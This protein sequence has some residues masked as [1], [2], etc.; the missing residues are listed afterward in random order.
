M[1]E[2]FDPYHKWLGIRPKDQPPNHYR[3]LGIELFENDLD[4][5]AS[6]ADQR[7]AHVRSY[8]TGKNSELSQKILNQIAAARVCLL[9]GRKKEQYDLALQGQ[10][11]SLPGT[12]PSLPV[13]VYSVESATAAPKVAEESPVLFSP[14]RSAVAGP[15]PRRKFGS[16]LMIFVVLFVLIGVVVILGSLLRQGRP[17]APGNNSA[18]VPASPPPKSP[19]S[20]G[21]AASVKQPS[22]VTSTNPPPQSPSPVKPSPESSSPASPAPQLN[23]GLPNKPPFQLMPGERLPGFN[24]AFYKVSFQGDEIA[25][26]RF[27]LRLNGY[28]GV[29]GQAFFEVRPKESQTLRLKFEREKNGRKHFWID[30]PYEILDKDLVVVY[31]YPIL[32]D[33]GQKRT[34]IAVPDNDQPASPPA[35][36]PDP[37]SPQPASPAP[38]S[39]KVSLPNGKEFNSR[40]FE[41]NVEAV[42][43]L[44]RQKIFPRGQVVALR[45]HNEYDAVL[46]SVTHG[47]LHG[48]VL[49]YYP[50]HKAMTYSA[51]KE[52]HRDGIVK[53]WLDN[54]HRC[55]WGQFSGG[56]QNGFSCFFVG[57]APCL[58][59][60]STINKISA[61]H[62]LRDLRVLKSYSTLDEALADPLAAENV[63]AYKEL[64]A[65]MAKNE[66]EFREIIKKELAR[67]GGGPGKK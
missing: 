63:K 33:I 45:P 17:P 34:P 53:T 50:N 40:L 20:P 51:Y 48:E 62:L 9:D 31:S 54:G 25:V 5:I 58:L 18:P 21:P 15:R 47:K 1:P 41:V 49:A 64:I 3:L 32:E 65:E 37:N 59:V 46:A 42:H 61:V 22:P 38:A 57:D 11:F 6:A 60:E 23:T 7:M 56:A 16:D 13:D 24:H 2:G 19:A 27:R 39:F 36:F 55:F 10:F 29:G 52:G 35:S 28:S 66:V 12:P 43:N 14:K 4:V 26:A 8:Q 44:L 30:Q 67:L